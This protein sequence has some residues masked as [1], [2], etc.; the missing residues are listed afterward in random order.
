LLHIADRRF[1]PQLEFDT[2]RCSPTGLPPLH[3]YEREHRG[4]HNCFYGA[5]FRAHQLT[6]RDPGVLHDV[7]RVATVSV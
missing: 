1:D 4:D 3:D 6:L 7:G 2:L 5:P